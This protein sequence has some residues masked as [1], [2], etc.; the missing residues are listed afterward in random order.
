M[1]RRILVP[2][3]GSEH[4]ESVLSLACTLAST[5]DAE[6]TL[7]RVVEYSSDV[8]SSVGYSRFYPNPLAEPGLAEKMRAK[9][10]AVNSRVK[11]YLQ[12]LA[13]SIETSAPKVSIEI[14]EGPV[15]DAILNSIKELEIDWIVMS[16]TGE[17]RN[18]WMMGAIANRILR[19]A[20][21][22]VVLW[23]KETGGSVPDLSSLQNIPLQKN[24]GSQYEYSR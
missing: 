9:K 24:I 23:R 16:T 5:S 6:I 18:P 3:D 20:Q 22:P 11:G 12:R 4:A 2:L 14:Q 21:V 19:E 1:V 15:V 8:F 13:S 7:L 10:E 17:D